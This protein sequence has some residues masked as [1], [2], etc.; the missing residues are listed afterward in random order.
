[1]E[2]VAKAIYLLNFYSG[3]SVCPATVWIISGLQSRHKNVTAPA[4]ELFFSWT[5]LQLRSSLF[6]WLRLQL[7]LLFVFTHYYFNCFGV[8]QVEWKINEIKCTKPG[9]YIKHFE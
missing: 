6:S 9:E 1:L 5:W 3:S 2:V 7:R 8:P 4:L